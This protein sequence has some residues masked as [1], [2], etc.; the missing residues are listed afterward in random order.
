MKYYVGI[1]IFNY[2]NW[3]DT[4]NCI[5]SIEKYNTAN[6]KCFIVGNGSTCKDAVYKLDSC[7]SGKF[8]DTYSSIIEENATEFKT[9]K[10]NFIVSED[11]SGYVRR[12]NTVYCTER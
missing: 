1:I 6:I 4:I 3:E 9:S 12:N 8:K 7:F 5:E 2:N 10:I 11:N